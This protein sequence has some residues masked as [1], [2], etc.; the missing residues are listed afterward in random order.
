ML[1]TEAAA[2]QS[3]PVGNV[4]NSFSSMNQLVAVANAAA[5]AVV[6]AAATNKNTSQTQRNHSNQDRVGINFMHSI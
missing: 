3:S 1:S 4:T 6:A 5:A 2:E